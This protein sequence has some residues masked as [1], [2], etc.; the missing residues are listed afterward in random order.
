MPEEG[1]QGVDE[2]LSRRNFTKMAAAGGSIS[3]AG[4]FDSGSDA[5]LVVM[6]FRQLEDEDPIDS[7]DPGRV[8]N[9]LIED[10]EEETGHEVEY[11][12][13]S[14]EEFRTQGLSIVGADD[15]PDVFETLQGPRS[16]G[17]V[18][19][20]GYAK[21]ISD[22]V[23]S[24]IWE[25]RPSDGWAYQDGDMTNMAEGDDLY[26]VPNQASG[27]P[28]WFSI[29]VLEDAGIDVEQI[30]HANDVSWD[31]F[32]D[33]C[34]QI[35]DEGYT[36]LALGNRVGGHIPYLMHAVF[37]K[38]FEYQSLLEMARGNNDMQFTDDE[39]VEAVELIEEWWEQ[40]FINEDTLALDEDEAQQRI[41]TG[42]AAFMTD[43]I[44][45][46]Y[47][48]FLVDPDDMG[49]MGEGWDYMWWPYRPDVFEDGKNQLHAH[50]NGAWT[51][52]SQVDDRDNSDVAAEFL[53]FWSDA[54]NE[55]FRSEHGNLIGVH[56][57]TNSF[58][59]DTVEAMYEDMHHEETIDVPIRA[60]QLFNSSVGEVIT[61]RGQ[62]LFTGIITPEELLQEM[63]D[64]REFN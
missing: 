31:E 33:M 61:N 27:F 15:A 4:C 12:F 40:D 45:I 38:T 5:D 43:G 16:S 19:D 10:F 25:S 14:I 62:D 32:N 2:L 29:P 53:E 41:F 63:E 1:T 3:L 17:Q 35:R 26:G 57:D 7:A 28:L 13:I 37:T 47:L 30:R 51:V 48:Y 6:G 50:P 55:N 18:V 8:Y 49:P 56:E 64:A 59:N 21:E 52:S 36:P 34:V 20:A 39:F 11:R 54:E 22:L 23:D 24:D 46:S 58:Y 60:D 44:W 42:D 9:S